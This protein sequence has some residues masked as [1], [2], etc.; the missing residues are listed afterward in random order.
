MP[1]LAPVAAPLTPLMLPRISELLCVTDALAP[2]AVALV[3]PASP[4]AL[5]P[6]KVVA[7][8]SEV[9]EEPAPSP[10]K[11]LFEPVLFALPAFLPKKESVDPVLLI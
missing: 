10:K 2:T 11:E 4:F 6:M 1:T 8:F 7:L 9:L 3:M 5:A